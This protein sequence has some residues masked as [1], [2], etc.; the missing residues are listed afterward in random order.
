MLPKNLGITSMLFKAFLIVAVVLMIAI[1]TARI[2]YAGAYELQLE[3]DRQLELKDKQRLA[4]LKKMSREDIK[5]LYEDR[6][7]FVKD[8]LVKFREALRAKDRRNESVGD[9]RRSYRLNPQYRPYK[10]KKNK[11]THLL[12]KRKN[13]S[14]PQPLYLGWMEFYIDQVINREIMIRFK[15]EKDAKKRVLGEIGGIKNSDP[16]L[17]ERYLKK[18]LKQNRTTFFDQFERHR[19]RGNS[20]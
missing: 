2:S 15:A 16:I 19:C 13:P 12:P 5:K 1:F 3:A 14:D 10:G 18:F 9:T 20:I 4:E 17:Y 11:Y 8:G 6:D 7:I